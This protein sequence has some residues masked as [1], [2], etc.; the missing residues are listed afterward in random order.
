MQSQAKGIW[1]H[2]RELSGP[3]EVVLEERWDAK[4]EGPCPGEYYRQVAQL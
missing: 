2:G 1:Y 4:A 3:G